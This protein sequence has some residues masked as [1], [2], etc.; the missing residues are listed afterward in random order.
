MGQ[1]FS[2]NKSP[3]VS[4]SKG[5]YVVTVSGRQYIQNPKGHLWV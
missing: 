4:F 3:V 1:V 5:V 2:F